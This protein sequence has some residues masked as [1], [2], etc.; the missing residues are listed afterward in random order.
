VGT[1]VDAPRNRRR[2]R[3]WPQDKRAVLRPVTTRRA[4]IQESKEEPVAT[5]EGM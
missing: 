2:T 4:G 5:L 3:T 1:K